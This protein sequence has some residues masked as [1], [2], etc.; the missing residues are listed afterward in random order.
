MSE[1]SGDE[2]R[3]TQ[4]E[5][6]RRAVA[7]GMESVFE[8]EE[9]VKRITRAFILALQKEMEEGAGRYLFKGIMGAVRKIGFVLIIFIFLFSLFGVPGLMAGIKA[10][11]ANGGG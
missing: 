11:F 3:E 10:M 5:A 9:K 8:D 7:E 6:L 2:R 4:T 1:W